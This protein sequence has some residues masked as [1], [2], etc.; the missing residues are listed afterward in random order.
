MIVGLGLDH[1]IFSEHMSMM[2]LLNIRVLFLSD[3][4]WARCGHSVNSQI[5]NQWS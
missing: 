5:R 2:K 4:A 1:A 3:E